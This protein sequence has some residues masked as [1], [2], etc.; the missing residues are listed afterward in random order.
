MQFYDLRTVP[1]GPGMKTSANYFLV[2][3]PRASG[4]NEKKKT[5]KLINS[6][7]KQVQLDFL[8][9]SSESARVQRRDFKQKPATDVEIIAMKSREFFKS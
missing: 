9:H 6:S 7:A 3:S 5:F 2:S 8:F 4:T 1:D